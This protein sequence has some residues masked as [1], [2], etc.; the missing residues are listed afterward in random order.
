VSL[1]RTLTAPP[2]LLAVRDD[3]GLYEVLGCS[4]VPV[5]H[6]RLLQLVLRE[7]ESE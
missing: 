1:L 6:R 3:D 4:R 5:D 7:I 2:H